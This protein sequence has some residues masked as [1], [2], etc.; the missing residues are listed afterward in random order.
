MEYI[1]I[2]QKLSKQGK[3]EHLTDLDDI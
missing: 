2:L 3:R 1:I